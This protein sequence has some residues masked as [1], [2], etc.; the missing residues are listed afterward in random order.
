MQTT[1]F[2]PKSHCVQLINMMLV[3]IMVIPQSQYSGPFWKGLGTDQKLPGRGGRWDG[4]GGHSFFCGQRGG[5]T[6][7]FWGKGGGSLIF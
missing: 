3:H 6:H 7:F 2:T 4:G 1:Q 5:V